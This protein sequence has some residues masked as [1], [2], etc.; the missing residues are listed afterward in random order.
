AC[1]G[2]RPTSAAGHPHTLVISLLPVADDA[3]DRLLESLL[4]PKRE[5]ELAR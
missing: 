1:A 2:G 5:T 4:L 3:L